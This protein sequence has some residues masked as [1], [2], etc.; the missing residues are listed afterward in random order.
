MTYL[1]N[2]GGRRS[3]SREFHQENQLREPSLLMQMPIFSVAAAE[4]IIRKV[5][6]SSSPQMHIYL[7][8]GVVTTSKS[9]SK[10]NLLTPTMAECNFR[11]I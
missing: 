7:V 3:D 8:E 5:N 4:P 1:E 6:S 10:N 9:S 2:K 11:T